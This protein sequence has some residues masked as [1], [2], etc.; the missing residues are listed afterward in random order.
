VGV[1]TTTLPGVVSVVAASSDQRP[2]TL[3]EVIGFA[4]VGTTTWRSALFATAASASFPV[5]KETEVTKET[6]LP[7]ETEAPKEVQLTK[8]PEATP[9]A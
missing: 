8:V 2:T 6:P 1:E 9:D 4:D 5:P 7:K 3:S